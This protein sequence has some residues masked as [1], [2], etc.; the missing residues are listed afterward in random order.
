MNFIF[1]MRMPRAIC[2]A[3][4]FMMLAAPMVPGQAGTQ[5]Q[6]QTQQGQTQQEQ[7]PKQQEEQ[8]QK[9]EATPNKSKQTTPSAPNDPF[10]AIERE[11]AA[12]NATTVKFGRTDLDKSAEGTA[13]VA[14][15]GGSLMVHMQAVNVPV[16]K[17]FEVPRYALWVYVPNYRV[18]MYIGDL[19]ITPA[20]KS[21]D[22][23]Q[24]G[25]SDTAYLFTTLPP[26]AVFGGLAL[27]AEPTRFEPIVNDALRPVL[28][29]LMPKEQVPELLSAVT[30]YS[31]SLPADRQKVSGQPTTSTTSPQ[32]K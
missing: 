24:R 8:S 16:P 27:T 4:L 18:K 21:K 30:L 3:L 31:G 17:H 15:R 25:Y 7:P 14:L 23:V 26:D 28:V 10:A 22:N 2:V 32:P 29:G 5:Q 1:S 12:G 11:V 19:P 13:Q 9:Q 6:G 20:S